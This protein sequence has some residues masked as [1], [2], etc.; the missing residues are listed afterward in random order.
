MKAISHVAY[1]RYRPQINAWTRTATKDLSFTTV[2]RKFTRYRQESGSYWKLMRMLEPQQYRRDLFVNYVYQYVNYFPA[3]PITKRS[4]TQ[5]FAVRLHQDIS[6][7]YDIGD[8]NDVRR[9]TTTRHTTETQY[10]PEHHPTATLQS[11]P[12]PGP[13]S[14]LTTP[15][16]RRR[17]RPRLPN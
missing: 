12:Q 3:Y 15:P 1:L 13:S 16:A 11:S 2:R 17:L 8:H 14:S 9:R 10:H 4:M 7:I 5:W 6:A